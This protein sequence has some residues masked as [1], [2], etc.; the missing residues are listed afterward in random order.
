[1]TS[2]PTRLLMPNPK[3]VRPLPLYKARRQGRE[4]MQRL[5]EKER[6]IWAEIQRVHAEMPLPGE[7][8]VSGGRYVQ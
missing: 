1:M 3:I 8:P 5:A 2:R 4:A 6:G 7:M